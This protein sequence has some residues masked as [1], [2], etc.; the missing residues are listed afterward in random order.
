ML[1]E[2]DVIKLKILNDVELKR[3]ENI[4]VYRKNRGQELLTD[5]EYYVVYLYTMLR[6]N[7]IRLCDR[8]HSKILAKLESWDIYRKI[9]YTCNDCIESFKWLKETLGEHGFKRYMDENGWEGYVE[10]EMKCT[11]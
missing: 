5:T 8:C 9:K 1:T 2:K 7:G 4:N 10:E 11:A 3:I 6:R